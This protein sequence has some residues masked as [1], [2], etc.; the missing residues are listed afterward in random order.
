V[1]DLRRVFEARV[2]ALRSEDWIE[3]AAAD[4]L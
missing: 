1:N 4:D 2:K 3:P